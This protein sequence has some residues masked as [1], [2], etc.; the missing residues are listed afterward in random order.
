M[1]EDEF[2]ELAA[3]YALDALSPA[4]LV[5][6][7]NARAQHPEWERLVVTDAETAAL[8]AESIT[9]VAPPAGIRDALLARIASAP[10]GEADA[11]SA[12]TR[13]SATKV[14]GA[15]AAP[16]LDAPL[17]AEPAEIAAADLPGAELAGA[18]LMEPAEA[19]AVEPADTPAVEPDESTVE[20]ARASPAAG[21]PAPDTA[22][23]QAIS[24][25]NW[26]RGMLGLAASLIL[27]VA[28]GFGAVALGQI[29]NRPAAVTAL[30]QIEAAPD[31]Q[32]ATAQVSDGGTATAHWSESVGKVVLVSHG[33]PSIDRNQS[34]EM[35][36]VRG[37]K[38]VS[39]GT[40]D[41]ST[42]ATV[43]LDGSVQPG[44]VIA[45]TVEQQGGSP[46]GQP[47]TDPIVTIPTA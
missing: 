20:P 18:P 47:T 31:A 13:P 35:W 14:V 22:T 10:R 12:D 32:S 37:G 21:E 15:Y 33:L 9:P 17:S 4:D 11:E 5:A 26:T 6:F 23:I 38:P 1:N 42:K 7:Q 3:G 24:R 2:A 39:A 41:D 25:R 29:I 46:S 16:R 45:V 40:F 27:L 30:E 36:F 44:D 28:L 19:P 8:L 34:F 43:L